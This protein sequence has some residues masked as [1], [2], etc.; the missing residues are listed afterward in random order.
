MNFIKI[1]FSLIIVTLT[2]SMGVRAADEVTAIDESKEKEEEK[3]YIKDITKEFSKYEGFFEAYQDTETSSIYLVVDEEQLNKEFIYFAHV[4]DGV[5]ASRRNR[6]SYL[7]NGIFKIEKYFD[8]LRL[9]R[10]NT[11]FSL[12]E[13]TALS[14]SS[15]ANISDSVLASL[16]I[17]ASNEDENRYLVDVTSLFLSEE[18]TPIK[19]IPSPFADE[20]SFRWGQISPTKSKIERII[21]Y[22]KNTDIE[23]ELVIESQPSFNYEEEDAAD[24]RNISIKMRYSFIGMPKNNFE[25][26]M[27]DQS[28]G[29]FS[30]KITDLSTD[31][32]TPYLDLIHK[33]DLQKKDPELAISEPIKPIL[34]WLENTTPLK[35][36]DYITEGLLAWNEA[37]LKAGIKNA[38]EVKIQP[39]DADWDAGDI[40]YN[41]LRWTSSPNA[42]FGGYGPSFVNPR[43]GE[44]IGADIMLEWVYATN[45]LTINDIF[46]S[47]HGSTDCSIGSI[48]QEANMMSYL[49]SLD[50]DDPEILK[51]SII[52]LTLHEVGHTLG[53]NHNFKA[54][55]LHNSKDVH[56]KKLTQKVGLTGSVMEYP[57]VNIAPLGVEQGDYYDTRTGPYD[58]WAIEFGYTPQLTAE[59]RTA[60]LSKSKLHEHMFANDSEDMRS[61]GKGIDPRAM[62]NDLSSEPIIYAEQRIKLVNDTISKLPSL[63][64]GKAS[65]WEEYRNAY[66]ILLRETSR[67]L[68]TVS[69]YIG[70]VYVNRSTPAQGS[71]QLPYEPVPALK[72]KEA[73]RVL[74]D[75]AFS[76]NAFPIN[77]EL[78]NL[79]QIERRG[80]DLYGEH[81]DPQVHKA[82]LNIQNKVFDQLLSPWVTYRITDTTL[83]GNDYEIYE[84]FN[85]LNNSIF[86]EDLN[87][88]VSYVRKNLQ[89]T[90]VR[91]LINILAADYYDEIT[92][93]AAYDSLRKIEKMMKKNSRDPGTKAHRS[94]ILWI[95]D[96]GLNRAN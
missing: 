32:A 81:E 94:L 90:Y 58:L 86:E 84:F 12:D 37:F 11:A 70:G 40:R 1:F 2:I 83:Y 13:R 16:P 8:T 57:A 22:P 42:P 3:E 47:S 9:S 82:I 87:F 21:N 93:A 74:A 30:E 73:M 20:E 14:R 49:T 35:F 25:P 38:I 17:K 53:L 76:V 28:I 15:G 6:G 52:R 19:P 66:K 79:L 60:L 77:G 80:F 27:A 44:I 75:H 50:E 51:Q 34:F 46:N 91:R 5:V 67:S 48:M 54:S 45:R 7:D 61:P 31:D 71:D 43:T 95:I 62:I 4:V 56:N 89:T 59:E 55:F 88:E 41:V 68:D 64:S 85:D 92:T 36:R 72:Q 69:R 65:S 24:P 96:S 26:R 39:D 78:L 63:L 29:Y 33:W 23:V 18:L 10:I